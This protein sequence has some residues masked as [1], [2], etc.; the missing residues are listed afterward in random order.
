MIEYLI[1]YIG[2]NGPMIL[3]IS[4]NYLLF[5]NNNNYNV[6]YIVGFLLTGIVNYILKGFFR[7][8]RPIDNEML[9]KM[10]EKYRQLMPFERYGMPSGHS[11]LVFYSTIYIYFVL[12]NIKILVFYLVISLLT[13][14]QR[15]TSRQHFFSQT[16]VGAFIG[17]L[18]GYGFYKYTRNHLQGSLKLKQDDNAPI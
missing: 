12:K 9:F 18:M 8:P 5:Q 6:I 14:Y 11:Q 1:D 17:S 7:Y 4:S 10:E 3:F 15:V 13:L 2:F 16:I